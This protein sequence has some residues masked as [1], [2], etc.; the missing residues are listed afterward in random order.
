MTK[1]TK[2]PAAVAAKSA[3]TKPADAP[4]KKPA[5]AQV[6]Y[7][8]V[9]KD[10]LSPQ[11]AQAANTTYR[12][13]LP[14][15]SAKGWTP[16]AWHEVKGDVVLCGN[17]LHFTRNPA[18]WWVEGGQV[19]VAEPEGIADQDSGDQKLV[20][21]RLRLLRPATAVELKPFGFRGLKMPTP[22]VKDGLPS[23]KPGTALAA[24]VNACA[25]FRGWRRGVSRRVSDTGMKRA[26]RTAIETGLPFERN[27]FMTIFNRLNGSEWIPDLEGL[28]Q[29][30]RGSGNTSAC[31]SIERHI[32]RKPFILDARRICLWDR[33]G[34]VPVGRLE[35]AHV[36]K[37]DDLAGE[38][39]V[40]TYQIDEKWHQRHG[41]PL[42]KQVLSREE[43][44]AAEAARLEAARTK[45]EHD[46]HRY[47]RERDDREVLRAAAAG[48]APHAPVEVVPGRYEYRGELVEVA[49]VPCEL[50]YDVRVHYEAVPDADDPRARWCFGD[51]RKYESDP[52]A[53]VRFW[54]ILTDA[55]WKEM[56]AAWRVDL[57]AAIDAR[58]NVAAL[59]LSIAETERA[60]A[61]SRALRDE[62]V[63]KGVALV[64]KLPPEADVELRAAAERNYGLKEHRWFAV[65]ALLELDGADDELDT[66]PR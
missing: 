17:G 20:A 29:L 62:L 41:H 26:L 10:G 27:D 8:K 24:V 58:A 64:E 52:E 56:R 22:K 34:L 21:R 63:L 31:V 40:S 39:T 42:R 3:T 5:K 14:T 13:S 33:I 45:K 37:I 59:D 66:E 38:I 6:L 7:F 19:F 35:A 54:N 28:Y 44:A 1:T 46:A 30:A 11:R 43:I 65:G 15:R 60:L 57:I 25:Y 16:G 61:K 51:V 36:T 9:L 47:E 48:V 53:R 18:A 32:G 49:K 12:W 2:K 4:A 23:T 50:G 55:D